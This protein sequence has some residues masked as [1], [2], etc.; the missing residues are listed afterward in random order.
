MAVRAPH[1]HLTLRAFCLGAFVFLG[2]A[3]EEGDDLPFA[4]EEHVQRQGP[5]LLRVPAA[6]ALLRRVARERAREAR[7]C[8][9]RARGAP[10]RAG[11]RDLRARPRRAE[12]DRGAGALPHRPARAPRLDRRGV[13][14]LRL[15]RP[16]FERAYA[17]L[18]RSLFGGTHAYAAVAPLVGLSVVDPG[19]ARRRD[20]LAR[21]GH[22][23]ARASLAGGAGA[24]ARRLR[25]RGRPLLRA[26]ARAATRAGRGAADAPAELADAVSAIRLATAAPGR[27]RAR[28]SSSG[29]T[30]GRTGSGRCCRSPRRSRRGSRRGSTRSAPRPTRDVLGRLALADADAPL[31]EALDRWEL[32]L[33]QN[34]P[35]R[36]EQLRGSLAGLLGDTL[37]ASRCRAARR[38]Q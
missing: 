29:S 27:R 12:A 13:R 14:R 16:A 18:E 3:L 17:E 19:R 24:V 37:G 30:G 31:A 21:R 22:R 33:F 20:S 1:L 25:P 38:R 26:R 34:E 7:R 36:S 28:C 8:P 11:G 2:R 9:L 32:S 5:A 23:R 35:F 10:S 6:R 4:F 15:G